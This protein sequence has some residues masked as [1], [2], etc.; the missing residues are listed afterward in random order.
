M[1]GPG[2]R[3]GC[4]GNDMSCESCSG[5]KKLLSLFLSALTPIGMLRIRK[6]RWMAR[7]RD[8]PPITSLL[9]PPNNIIHYYFTCK[10]N[11]SAKD[12]KPNVKRMQCAK[13]TAN[14]I[15]TQQNLLSNG[16]KM[17]RL[18]LGRPSPTR[19]S[20]NSAVSNWLRGKGCERRRLWLSARILNPSALSLQQQSVRRQLKLH[21]RWVV[22]SL[23]CL[24]QRM[25]QCHTS[26]QS[27]EHTAW[28][29][30]SWRRIQSKRWKSCWGETSWNVGLLR[31]IK[32]TWRW[33][34]LNKSNQYPTNWRWMHSFLVP[35]KWNE[36]GWV[37]LDD[38]DSIEEL[39]AHLNSYGCSW[40]S[41]F[42]MCFVGKL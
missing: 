28:S 10:H 40:V 32:R 4:G 7:R 27:L 36:E 2:Q 13:N 30:G 35:I 20:T 34:A 33:A 31:R 26:K 29:P 12:L 3:W 21:V 16:S 15:L 24:W 11:K 8:F 19:Y 41:T 38:D 22:V 6:E 23:V 17:R 25:E 5:F 39:E 9:L 37:F 1:I 42:W 14:Y 18:G